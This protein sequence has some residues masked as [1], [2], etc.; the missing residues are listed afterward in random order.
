[1][2]RVGEVGEKSAML[3]WSRG[4]RGKGRSAGR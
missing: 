4:R 1:M 3:E 2:R